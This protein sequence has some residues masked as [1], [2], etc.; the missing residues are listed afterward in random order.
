MSSPDA[1]ASLVDR[2]PPVGAKLDADALL[3]RFLEYTMDRGIE[4]YPAQ[5][6]AILELFDGKNVILATPT[7]S[8]KSLVALALCFKALAEN[9]CIVIGA[10]PRP[11]VKRKG[12]APRHRDARRR[13]VGG[14]GARRPRHARTAGGR[15][16][17]DTNAAK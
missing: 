4:L 2:L 6:E 1:S 17:R 11:P 9:K 13:C 12:R 16:R 7:G 10:P 8:G 15:E 5:E 3:E 14:H